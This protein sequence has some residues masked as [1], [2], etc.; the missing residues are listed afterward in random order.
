MLL[1]ERARANFEP[2]IGAGVPPALAAL[3][4]SCLAVVPSKRPTAEA[5]RKE[6]AGLAAPS[7]LWPLSAAAAVETADGAPHSENTTE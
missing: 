5:A 3:L 2:V 1:I 6:M 4:L 7:V